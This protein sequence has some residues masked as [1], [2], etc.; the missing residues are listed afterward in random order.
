LLKDFLKALGDLKSMVKVLLDWCNHNKMEINWLKTKA[1]IITSIRKNRSDLPV[2]LD[3]HNSVE[4]VNEFKLLGVILDSKLNFS[5]QVLNL[6]KAITKKLFI[7]KNMF[8]LSSAV[9][10]QFFKTFILPYF[11]YCLSISIY[12][13]NKQIDELENLYNFC[14]LKLFN[15][16]LRFLNLIDKYN[17]LKSLNLFPFKIRLFY[18]LSLFSYK[19][20]NNLILSQFNILSEKQNHYNLRSSSKSLYIIP[21]VKT[22]SGKKRLSDLLPLFLN[23][24]LR[25]SVFLSLKDFKFLICTNLFHFLNDF[26][27]IFFS[28]DNAQA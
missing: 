10:L 27:N 2:E 1:M 8:H 16:K 12:F 25:N 7:I 14:L 24:V 15:I 3:L 9:R 22:E 13:N 4:V 6:K 28:S 17:L 26:I 19:I 11:D 5:N 20:V 18:R 23:N 21:K